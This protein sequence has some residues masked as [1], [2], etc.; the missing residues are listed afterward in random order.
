MALA[1]IQNIRNTIVAV[2]PDRNVC[3]GPGLA[4][5]GNNVLQDHRNLFTARPFSGAKHTHDQ[6][7]RI[8]VVHMNGHIAKISVKCIEK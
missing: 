3:L 1:E 2:P 7:A 5:M 6:V 8:P 4:D